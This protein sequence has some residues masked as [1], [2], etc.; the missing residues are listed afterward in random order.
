MGWEIRV[1]GGPSFAERVADTI[2]AMAKDA[3]RRPLDDSW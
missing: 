1:L 2:V 3:A